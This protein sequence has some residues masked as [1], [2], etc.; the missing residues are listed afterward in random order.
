[1]DNNISVVKDLKIFSWCFAEVLQ[2]FSVQY[3]N[4]LANIFRV[5]K[6]I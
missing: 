6:M 3:K 2:I 4:L 5:A 1:M